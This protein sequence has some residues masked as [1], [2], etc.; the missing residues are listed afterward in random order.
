VGGPAGPAGAE[1]GGGPMFLLRR[2][3]ET[4]AVAGTWKGCPP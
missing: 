3:E 4:D 2:G 1:R